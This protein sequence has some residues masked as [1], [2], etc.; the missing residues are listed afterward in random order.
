MRLTH[1]ALAVRDQERSRRFYETYF[2]FGASSQRYPDGVLIV[3]DDHGFDLALGPA[4][5]TSAPPSLF[6]F[7]FRCDEPDQVRALLQ[8]VT[9]DGIEVVERYDEPGFVNFKCLDPDCYVVEA[10]WQ[11]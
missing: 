6:H 1:L 4:D 2:G 5:E 7:G 11:P 8:R 9:E 10:Y 3:R